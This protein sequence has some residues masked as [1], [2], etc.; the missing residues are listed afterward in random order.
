MQLKKYQ[1]N[2]LNVLQ[3]FFEKCRIVGHIEAFKQISSDSEIAE[4]LVYLKNTYTAWPAIPNTPQVCIKIP[5]GGGKTIIAAHAIKIVAQT[6][7][8]K[9]YP[10]VLWFVPTDTIRRQTA[11]ALKNPRHPYRIALNEQYEGKVRIFDLDEKFNI[12]PADAE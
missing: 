9:E 11:E 4:R 7:C 10:V 12:R 3:S 1:Q 2:S 5:T 6:W 8:D